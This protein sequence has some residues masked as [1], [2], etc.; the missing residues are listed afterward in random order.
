MRSWDY[1][2]TAALCGYLSVGCSNLPEADAPKRGGGGSDVSGRC[3][4]IGAATNPLVTEWS[5]SEKAHLQSLTASQPVA[6]RFAGCDLKVIPGCALPGRYVWQHTTLATDTLEIEDKNELYS[7][8]PIGAVS[9]EATLEQAGKLSVQSIV[10]GQ[11]TLLG[12]D[13]NRLALGPGCAE[14]THVVTRVS[15][16]AFKMFSGSDFSGKGGVS[17]PAVGASAGTQRSESLLRE[18]GDPAACTKATAEAPAAQCAGPIQLFLATLRPEQEAKVVSSGAVQIAIPGPDDWEE[19]WSLRDQGGAM[20]CRLP[21]T[22]WVNPGS[23]YYLMRESGPDTPVAKIRLPNAFPHP[24]GSQLE[25]SYQME[26]GAPFWSTLAVYGVGI[27]ATLFGGYALGMGISGVMAD[28]CAAGDSECGAARSPGT[29]FGW[30]ALAFGIAG[31]TLWW[32]LYSQEERFETYGP[33]D[34]GSSASPNRLA[35]APRRHE[36]GLGYYRATF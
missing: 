20:I 2:G 10:A 26:K 12:T 18:S 13:L 25:A 28:P 23:G 9:L 17:V 16:G 35:R 36:L 11:L 24:P 33:S 29:Y 4:S 3:Q 21:C 27:P 34:S 22:Q 7:K 6:V 14:A 5:A 31:G 19:S 15:V 1:L 30:S 8:L 32:S